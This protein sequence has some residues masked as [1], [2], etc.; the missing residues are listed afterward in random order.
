MLD[1]V[2][3]IWQM[4]DPDNRVNL[5]PGMGAEEMIMRRQSMEDQ[6]VDLEC[7]LHTEYKLLNT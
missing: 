5:I 2:W 4:Q 7:A 6:V 3:W 1:R